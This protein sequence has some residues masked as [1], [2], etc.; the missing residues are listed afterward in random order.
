VVYLLPGQELDLFPE[1]IDEPDVCRSAPDY[2]PGVWMECYD[3]RLA[4]DAGCFPVKL[5]QDLLMSDVYAVESA[6]GDDS[7]S[8]GRQVVYISIYVHWGANCPQFITFVA[9][10]HCTQHVEFPLR[11]KKFTRRPKS[12]IRVFTRMH[13]V[14]YTPII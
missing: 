3:H 7:A 6:N 5:F 4:I 1:G 10:C 14:R 9:L 13:F 12:W 8:K 11:K 2:F